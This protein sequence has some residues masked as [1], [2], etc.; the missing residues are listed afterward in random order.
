MR[1]IADLTQEQRRL[2]ELYIEHGSYALVGHYMGL[3][4]QTIKNKAHQIIQILE[5]A[6]ITQACIRYDRANR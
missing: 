2:L 6:S 1:T 4:E 3:A 5:V